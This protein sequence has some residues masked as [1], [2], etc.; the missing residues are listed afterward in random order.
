MLSVVIDYHPL[1][2]EELRLTLLIISIPLTLERHLIR[3]CWIYLTLLLQVNFL[4][5][6]VAIFSYVLNLATRLILESKSFSLTFYCVWTPVIFSPHFADKRL[7]R[8]TAL[9]RQRVDA[10]F[11]GDPFPGS[12]CM[13]ILIYIDRGGP[14]D[15]NGPASDDMRYLA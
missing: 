2:K 11:A 13:A 6:T 5:I 4:R 15:C 7:K 10:P 14:G 1:R 12:L 8:I 9:V 3:I